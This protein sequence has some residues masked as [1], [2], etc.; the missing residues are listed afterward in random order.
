MTE[1]KTEETISEEMILVDEADRETGRGGKLAVHRAGLLHRA[2]SVFLWRE[3]QLL[4]QRRAAGKYHSALLWANTCCSHPRP[5]EEVLDAARRRLRE[6]CGIDCPCLR[7]AFCFT[8]RAE[9]KNGLTEHE[10]DHVLLGYHKGGRFSPD[11]AEIAELRWWDTDEVR[12]ALKERPDEFAAWF[13]L[14]APRVIDLLT[15]GNG[16]IID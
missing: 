3:G 15:P 16:G 12:R 1:E 10:F 5:G 6:E 4:L 8:Y 9:L 7:E 13:R 11:P 2:F 14:A